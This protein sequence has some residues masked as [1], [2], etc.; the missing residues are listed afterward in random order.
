MQGNSDLI[1]GILFLIKTCRSHQPLLF[2]LSLLPSLFRFSLSLSIPLAI[3]RLLSGNVV[4]LF[5]CTRAM[6]INREERR[7]M[8]GGTNVSEAFKMSYDVIAKSET[9]L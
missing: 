8:E 3:N 7:V 6:T 9:L 5:I 1:T 4:C 2:C